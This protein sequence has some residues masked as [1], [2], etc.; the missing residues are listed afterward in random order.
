M[1]GL[2][3]LACLL[4]VAASREA[5]VVQAVAVELVKLLMAAVVAS[6]AAACT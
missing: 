5:V 6:G 1:L 2:R 4:W 3:M